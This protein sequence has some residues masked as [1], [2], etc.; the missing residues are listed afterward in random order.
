VSDYGGYGGDGY[1]GYGTYSSRGG[2]GGVE[3]AGHDG[4]ATESHY[5]TV[6]ESHYGTVSESHYQNEGPYRTNSQQSNYGVGVEDHSYHGGANLERDGTGGSVVSTTALGS[7]GQGGFAGIDTRL[8][9]Y[10]SPL[11]QHTEE[12]HERA[13]LPTA[14]Y[15]PVELAGNEGETP[16]SPFYE[17]RFYDVRYGTSRDGGAHDRWSSGSGE[18]PRRGR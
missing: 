8:G 12:V 11:Q 10:H 7:A 4:Y 3:Y 5:G 15:D 2:G 1:E 17:R 13:E 18:A 6:S 14:M 16:T 9:M